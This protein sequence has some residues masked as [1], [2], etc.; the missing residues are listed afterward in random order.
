MLMKT[1]ASL[2]LFLMEE[3]ACL[4]DVWRLLKIGLR[5]D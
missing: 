1:A 4:L 2:A 5:K 3:A